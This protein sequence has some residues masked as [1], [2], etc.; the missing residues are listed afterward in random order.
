M[1]LANG[2]TCHIVSMY[3]PPDDTTRRH[4]LSTH[5]RQEVESHDKTMHCF[6][7]AGDLNSDMSSY[8]DPR[9]AFHTLLHDLGLV[10]LN[11]TGA[12]NLTHYPHNRQHSPSM[13]DDI[14]ISQLLSEEAGSLFRC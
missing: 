10:P 2:R 12:R 5:L 7:I 3:A 8:P 6:I 1:P 11:A 13:L 4:A 14:L 9:Q